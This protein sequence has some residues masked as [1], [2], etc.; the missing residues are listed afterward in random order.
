MEAG[1]ENTSIEPLEFGNELVNG[2]DKMCYPA[3]MAGF[4]VNAIVGDVTS[5]VFLCTSIQPKTMIDF[6][7]STFDTA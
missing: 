3:V 1:R 2:I 7:I 6:V 4:S 5:M